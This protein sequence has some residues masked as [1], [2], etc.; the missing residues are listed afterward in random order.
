MIAIGAAFG[1]PPRVTDEQTIWELIAYVDGHN[2]A[3]GG[4]K[5][6]PPTDDEFDLMLANHK[7]GR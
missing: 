1:W 2:R 6:E 7:I 5:V 3:N 4:E